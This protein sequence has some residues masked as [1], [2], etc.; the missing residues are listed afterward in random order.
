M[1]KEVE[2]IDRFSNSTLTLNNEN[3]CHEHEVPM[4]VRYR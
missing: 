3:K 2:I 4:Y 1:R